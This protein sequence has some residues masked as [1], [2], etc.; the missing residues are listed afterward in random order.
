M[1]AF[2]WFD[3]SNVF[4]LAFLRNGSVL[5]SLYVYAIF[6]SKRGIRPLDLVNKGARRNECNEVV[7]WVWVPTY[8]FKYYISE[9]LQ[10]YT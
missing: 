2:C 7:S 4:V 3:L 10:C 5:C 1:L 6:S 9:K 8:I